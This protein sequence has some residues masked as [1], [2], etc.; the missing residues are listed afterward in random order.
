MIHGELS[1][2]DDVLR[3]RRPYRL[4][5]SGVLDHDS[6]ESLQSRIT[7]EGWIPIDARISVGQV[8]SV[9]ERLG[10]ERLYGKDPNAP[11]RE[12]IANAA[13]AI[14]ARRAIEERESIWGRIDVRVGKDETGDWLEVEDNGIGM[15]AAVLRGPLLEFG[16]SYWTSPLARE[17]HPGLYSRGFTSTGEFGIGFFSIFMLGTRVR[18]LSQPISKPGAGVPQPHVLEFENGLASRPLM[19]LPDESEWPREPGTRVR[20]WLR[21]DPNLPKLLAPDIPEFVARMVGR[22]TPEQSD[23]RILAKKVARVAPCLDVDTFATAYGSGP[24]LSVAAEDWLRISFGDLSARLGEREVGSVPGSLS[25]CEAIFTSSGHP[26]ARLGIP[27]TTEAATIITVGGLATLSGIPGFPG[28]IR[29]GSPD[30]ARHKAEPMPLDIAE[31]SAWL[32]KVEGGLATQ[33]A[34]FERQAFAKGSW[35]ASLYLEAGLRPNKIPCFLHA[36]DLV[37]AEQ[38]L[39]LEIPEKVSIVLS[40]RCQWGSEGDVQIT[41]LYGNRRLLLLDNVIIAPV[42]RADWIHHYLVPVW[43]LEILPDFVMLDG[44]RFPWCLPLLCLETIALKLGCNI[45]EL[46][47]SSIRDD[48]GALS[49]E[50]HVKIGTY[51]GE[52]LVGTVLRLE[53]PKI[54]A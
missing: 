49:P 53:D 39:A 12:L 15:S 9:V 54:S 44:E 50:F 52:D 18:V 2:I 31:V 19:R 8:T 29:G 32:R 17:E 46:V 38:L 42:V 26:I 22:L 1:R 51:A 6:A 11:L 10:G 28:V 36:G 48:D 27:A 40:D 7:V 47:R 41:S 45:E 23:T 24:V 33:V 16:T 25:R 21:T 14:R 34:N 13:D 37:S 20:V 5:A 4:A 3:R 35:Y 43:G 30:L